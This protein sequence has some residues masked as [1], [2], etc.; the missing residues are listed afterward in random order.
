MSKKKI[1]VPRIKSG[2]YKS[3]RD[4]VAERRVSDR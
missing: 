1:T 2:K 3:K 4:I